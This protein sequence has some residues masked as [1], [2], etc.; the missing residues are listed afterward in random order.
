MCCTLSVGF[1]GSCG[2]W[3]SKAI[4]KAKMTAAQKLARYKL[5]TMAYYGPD[6]YVGNGW[7]ADSNLNDVHESF[8]A[9]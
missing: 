4:T 6:R 7:K 1:P 5:I 8:L 2:G 9:H 3:G